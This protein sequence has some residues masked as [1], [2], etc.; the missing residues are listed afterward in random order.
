M[1]ISL[2]L[3]FLHSNYTAMSS[4]IIS[5]SAFPFFFTQRNNYLGLLFQFKAHLR[6]FDPDLVLDI[7]IPSSDIDVRCGLQVFPFR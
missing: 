2:A 5:D 6:R 1:I 4:S 3:F 7:P